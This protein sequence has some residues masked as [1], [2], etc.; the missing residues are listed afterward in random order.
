MTTWI[1]ST[2][3]VG[4]AEH[5]CQ[6]ELTKWSKVCAKLILWFA[7]Y[8]HPA[9]AM[10]IKPAC[11][12]THCT[13][14]TVCRQ[15]LWNVFH[16]LALQY[17]NADVDRDTHTNC[18]PLFLLMKI[19]LVKC[20]YTL[21]SQQTWV[22]LAPSH[23]LTASQSQNNKFQTNSGN[24]FFKSLKSLTLTLAIKINGHT[25]MVINLLT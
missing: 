2:T 7:D 9:A 11:S 17:I 12:L 5:W 6:P 3:S 15:I 10:L 14:Y 20:E 24:R 1:I 22:E 19:I 21:W 23:K 25:N 16:K 4:I 18:L 8:T 13:Q